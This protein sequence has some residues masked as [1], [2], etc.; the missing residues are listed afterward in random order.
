MNEIARNIRK[1]AKG[2]PIVVSGEVESVDKTNMLCSV[3]LGDSEDK[4][5]ASLVVG[6]GNRGI[7]QIPEVGS[8]VVVIMMSNTVGFVV[9]IEKT[10]EII[11]NGGENGGLI[12]IEDLVD[13]LNKMSK[14]ID[15]IINAIEK[16]TIA[17]QDGGAALK[18]SI[19]T[20]LKML[21]DKEDF[22]DIEDKIVKH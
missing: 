3:V 1:M 5:E 8:L 18:T 17:A 6:D 19:V 2:Q 15:G 22:S 10:Q 12:N 14:R 11:I 13:N 16:G 4:I 9:L 20:S 21:T 7:I